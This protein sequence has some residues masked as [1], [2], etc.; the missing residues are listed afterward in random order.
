[1]IKLD[2][3]EPR[4]GFL[5]ACEYWS[6][7]DDIKVSITR[8]NGYACIEVSRLGDIADQIYEATQ[9]TNDFSDLQLEI[10]YGYTIVTPSEKI[11]KLLQFIEQIDRNDLK[12]GHR[13]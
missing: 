3:V 9:L 10:S 11:E 5:A 12:A 1:M 13:Y 7:D 4:E 8:F 6:I 2:R